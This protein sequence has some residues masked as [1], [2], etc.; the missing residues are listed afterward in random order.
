MNERGPIS[1]AVQCEAATA[2]GSRCRK[3]VTAPQTHCRDHRDVASAPPPRDAFAD[4]V[5]AAL[6]ADPGVSSPRSMITSPNVTSPSEATMVDVTG[7]EGWRAWL[8]E[9]LAAEADTLSAAE[10]EQLGTHGE[11]LVDAVLAESTVNAYREHFAGFKQWCARIGADALPASPQVVAAYLVTIAHQGTTSTTGD[12]GASDAEPGRLA[13]STLA[14]VA[15]AIGTVHRNHGHTDPTA[16]PRVRA[17]IGGYS[18]QHA[19][20]TQQA[21]GITLEELGLMAVRCEL[22]PPEQLRDATLL[23]LATHPL[24]ET[25]ANQ[26]SRL[27]WDH[28]QL[29]D[30]PGLP[31]RLHLG[32]RIGTV[33]IPPEDT[34]AICPVRHLVRWHA[35]CAGEGPVFPSPRDADRPTSRQGLTQRV[36][37][38]LDRAGVA[39]SARLGE[40]ARLS[41]TDRQLLLEHLNAPTLRQIR[42]L[43]VLSVMWWAGL[44]ADETERLDVG[45]LDLDHDRGLTVRVRRSKND[46]YGHG[47][48]TPIVH[49]RGFIACPLERTAQWLTRYQAALGR[50]LV[51]DD[52]AFPQLNRGVGGRL[53]YHGINDLVKHWA[54]AAGIEPGANERMSSHA[55][56]AGQTTEM[57]HRDLSAEEIARHQRRRDT[58]H[59]YTYYRP[60]NDWANNPTARLLDRVASPPPADEAVPE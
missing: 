22:P 39:A 42:D 40:L 6:R 37:Q 24:V 57:L 45:D 7:S 14:L 41:V 47:A 33:W 56:R 3:L 15:T 49:Q 25:T 30:E 36:D 21:H 58:R 1:E 20:A 19:R 9:H 53:G 38:L 44:R 48:V 59:V 27:R 35:Q 32:G 51:A 16:H 60:T 10:L 55:L 50:D 54:A 18:R 4:A 5:A 34:P 17:L 8:G 28:V 12:R 26:L 46:P 43:A 11:Q 2:S 31:A 23:A 52:P 13:P 29:P